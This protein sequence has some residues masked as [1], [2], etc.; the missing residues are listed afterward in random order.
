MTTHIHEQLLAET[1]ELSQAMRDF[2]K[3]PL[4]QIGRSTATENAW[5]VTRRIL[6]GGRV[7][8]S[9]HVD[10]AKIQSTSAVV[11]ALIAAATRCRE[12]RSELS[13]LLVEPNVI[14][15]A[16][17][18]AAKSAGRH[19]RLALAQACA[20]LDSGKCDDDAAG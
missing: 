16:F 14:D 7:G 2:W 4:A 20:S 15:V 3:V 6:L 18:S 1:H 17:R 9:K 5:W 11:Q 8:P 19:V 12:R 13:L 10:A